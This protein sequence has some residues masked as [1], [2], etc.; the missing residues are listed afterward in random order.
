MKMTL[1]SSSSRGERDRNSETMFSLFLLWFFPTFWLR[2]SMERAFWWI[3]VD[4][5]FQKSRRRHLSSKPEDCVSARILTNRIQNERKELNWALLWWII[6]ESSAMITTNASSRTIC[7][8]V[9]VHEFL[10]IAIRS[11]NWGKECAT[12]TQSWKWLNNYMLTVFSG[13]TTTRIVN[14]GTRR[15]ITSRDLARYHARSRDAIV[16]KLVDSTSCV[17]NNQRSD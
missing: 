16:T 15:S 8:A 1:R 9:I 14:F 6:I 3:N 10:E 7:C 12:E 13:R 11:P 2:I 5:L 17:I 4:W